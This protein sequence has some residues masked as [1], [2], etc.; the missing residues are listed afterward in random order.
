MK[1]LS[2]FL[3]LFSFIRIFAQLPTPAVV[4][5][6][7]NW[8]GANFIALK[9][10][11]PRYNVIHISFA[12]DNGGR[13]Y[14]LKFVP[15]GYTS[16][17]FKNEMR[18][19][20]LAGK[21]VFIS[22]GGQNDPVF[23]DS[24]VEKE[25]FVTSVNKIVDD[26]GFDGIDIDLEG[27]SLKFNSINIPNPGDIRQQYMIDAIKE[28]MANYRTTHNKKLLLTMAPE[29]VY[30]QGGLSDWAVTNAHGGA[31]LPMI[32][33]LSDSIDM[34]NVQLYNSG[35]M[36]GLDGRV[37][38]QSSAD[39]VVAMTE[40]VI[41]GY[42]SKGN[43]GTF[44]GF[45]A[46]K[47]GVGLP[48]CNG[49]G[50]VQPQE[51]EAAMKYLTGK[52]PKPGT[53]TLQQAGGYPDLRGMMTW[54]IN[55]DKRCSPSYG[56]VALYEQ[57][58]SDKPFIKISN[59][60]EIII[61]KEEEGE[62]SVELFNGKFT[63]P[64][65]TDHWS[66]SNLPTNVSIAS[67]NR[68]NDSLAT[69][70]ISGNSIGPGGN[71]HILDV[72]V[73]IDSNGIENS[74]N[75]ISKGHGV[76]LTD[77]GYLLP[78]RIEAEGFHDMKGVE[79]RTAQDATNGTKLGNWHNGDYTEY[80]IVVPDSGGVYDIELRV[81]TAQNNVADY[82]LQ[83]DG[84]ELLRT[85]LE[86]TGGWEAW[87]TISHEIILPAGEHKFRF[88]TYSGHLGLN[89]LNFVYKF[90]VGLDESSHTQLGIY[91][92]PVNSSLHIENHLAGTVTITDI[93]GKVIIETPINSS[94]HTLDVSNLSTGVY[95]IML[96]DINNIKTYSKFIK[97]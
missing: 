75:S 21:K 54:S 92:N 22:I 94:N 34:L 88:Y 28:I 68:E 11:D 52:G 72:T 1:N 27:T 31:Y 5:Y 69:I 81:A 25:V 16:T 62:I 20:Q 76:K 74:S 17:Q 77:P 51:L 64:I 79:I 3:L 90:P 26:W 9:D 97:E 89:W 78:T 50:Y 60:E 83:L 53:Y 95:Q 47:V 91:P 66:V 45:P 67:I 41:K 46:S 37:Y 73:T 80:N 55:S 8:R 7:E 56:Y 87:K 15:A 33:A 24:L 58:F 19:H 70:V 59:K 63:N 36:F 32:E 4:G 93:N 40:A 86:S 44:S 49:Y 29:T 42:T 12:T 23:L 6:W 65:N 30:V 96:N 38:E 84:Q 61:T 57:L 48:G 14:D 2:F 39:F 71:G 10:I 18:N 82:S 43:I 13:D 85:K 35:S